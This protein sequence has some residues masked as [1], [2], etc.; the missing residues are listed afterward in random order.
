MVM[1]IGNTQTDPDH[2]GSIVTNRLEKIKKYLLFTL[3]YFYHIGSIVTNRL[4]G[5]DAALCPRIVS[6]TALTSGD[7]EVGDLSWL[8]SSSGAKYS[9]S[10]V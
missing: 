4:E 10:D 2:I 5:P 9:R 6:R 3:F 1:D 8:G 7:W